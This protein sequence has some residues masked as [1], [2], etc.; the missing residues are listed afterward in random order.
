MPATLLR[1]EL[2]R[3]LAPADAFDHRAEADSQRGFIVGR[4]ELSRRL[5][6]ADRLGNVVGPALRLRGKRRSKLGIENG[7]VA[8]LG[9][10]GRAVAHQSLVLD[11]G[12]KAG[13]QPVDLRASFGAS[14]VDLGTMSDV[15]E[16]Q[17]Q[18]RRPVAEVVINERRRHPGAFRHLP[19]AASMARGRLASRCAYLHGSPGDETWGSL[20]GPGYTLVMDNPYF[21]LTAELNAGRLRA[22]LSSGQAVVA[23]RL[24]I[25]SKDGDWILREEQ[26]ALDHVLAVLAAHGAWYRFGA[27]L[28]LRWL[29]GGWSSHFEF[30]R[31]PLRF[32][33]DFVTR[34]P[35]VS[36]EALSQLWRNAEQSGNEV[37]PLEPLAALKLTNREKDYAV[38]GELA[39]RMTD[40]ESQL[41]YSR[42]SRD[43]ITLTEQ[44]PQAAECVLPRR[45]LL[46][47]VAAGRDALDEALD[48]ER[49]QLMRTNEERL[50][51]YDEA[52]TEWRAAWPAFSSELEGRSLDETHPRVVARAD[53]LLPFNPLF[54]RET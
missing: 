3:E 26:E 51:K 19:A 39:R 6:A 53:G 47:I 31:G 30:R 32:R 38:I 23:H 21:V 18:Q 4:V 15:F 41:L 2:A 40:P 16:R 17:P 35:R 25:M 36:A 8:Q 27:P 37:V 54:D 29:A 7:G 50:A 10:S 48:R 52:A 34:P 9:P 43:L 13:D 5:G 14:A 45:P 46:A 12:E 28:D 11:L 1:R 20:A 49:R 42:S 24:A 22:L 44:Y 33:T